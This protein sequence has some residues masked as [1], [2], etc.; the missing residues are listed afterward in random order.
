MNNHPPP[1]AQH[2]AIWVI[3]VAVVA[4]GLTTV[5]SCSPSSA[6]A[7]NAPATDISEQDLLREAAQYQND[8]TF[9]RAR[10]LQS[11][12][13]P[14]NDY[15]K[16]RRMHYTENDWEALPLLNPPSR[17]VLPCDIGKPPP[18]PDATWQPLNEHPAT[19]DRKGLEALG[20]AVFFRYPAQIE[21]SMFDVLKNADRSA[22]AGLWQT[23]DSVGGLR[24]VSLKG[25]VFPAFSCAT[26]HASP[27]GKGRI[28][29]GKPNHAFD[30]F[31]SR[32]EFGQKNTERAPWGKGRLDLTADGRFNPVPIPDLRPVHFQPRLHRTANVK[33]SLT[34]MALRLE[35]GLIL[36]SRSAVRPP[37]SLMF[38]LSAYLYSLY[39]TLANPQGGKGQAVF[40]RHC[41]T[42]HQGKGLT[43]APVASARV[44]ADAALADSPS[45]GTGTIQVPSLR[46]LSGRLLLLAD[47]HIRSVES[48][49]DPL[50]PDPAHRFGLELSPDDRDAL[51]TYLKSL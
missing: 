7:Q 23:Q 4:C 17:P 30:L 46:G 43:G 12:V 28:E 27:D 36:A 15:A 31:V 1:P 26:C 44:G 32:N 37:R 34:A 38:A 8:A 16:I 18:K 51:L 10:L 22:R 20:E 41:A 48:L 9:R 25:G 6:D 3:G 21:F 49:L 14:E 5:A 24:W 19:A 29:A 50:R 13:N 33:N 2:A 39:R 35:T 42:C 40:V 11:L 45:R 47:G